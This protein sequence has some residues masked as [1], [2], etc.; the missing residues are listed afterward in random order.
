MHHNLLKY[1]AICCVGVAV[2][3]TS[4]DRAQANFVAFVHLQ[5]DGSDSVVLS[6]LLN[7]EVPGVV[8]GD[9]IFSEFFYSTLPN[10]DMPDPENV[11]VFGFEDLEGNLGISFHGVFWDLPD[12]GPSDALIR[13]TVEVSPDGLAEGLRIS[14]AHLFLG[15]VSVGDNSFLAV[16]E[17]FQGI[18]QTLNT[19]V[20]TLGGTLNQNLDDEVFFGQ[21]HTKL[22]VTKDILAFSGDANMPAV[23]RVIDQSFSQVPEPASL[24]VFAMFGLG[25]ATARRRP[26][27]RDIGS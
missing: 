23:T 5:P 27:Q 26:P 16:D 15:G 6:D 17:S 14:D 8:V 1:L 7:G 12:G 19:F 3:G 22:R 25:L 9:K 10:D 2:S 18:N 21:L 24:V 4:A 13:Y 11:K 20:T